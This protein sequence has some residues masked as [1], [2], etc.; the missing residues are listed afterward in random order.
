MIAYDIISVL[1]FVPPVC[2]GMETPPKAPNPRPRPAR[3]HPHPEVGVRAKAMMV[4]ECLLMPSMVQSD[5]GGGK[6]MS[7]R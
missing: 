1:G 7:N 6:F 5:I 2:V 4:S 3:R